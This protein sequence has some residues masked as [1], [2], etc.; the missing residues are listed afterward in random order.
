MWP[1]RRAGRVEVVAVPRRVQTLLFTDIVGSTDRLRELGDAPWAALLAR[2]HSVIRDVLATH[3]GREVNT[4]GDGF[5]ARFE[6]PASAVRAAVAAVAAVA[7]LGIEIRTGLHTGEVE[8]DRDEIAG[9]GVHL[10]ARVMAEAYPGQVL[11]TSTVRDLLAG[12][13]LGFVDQGVRELKGFAEIWR[14]FALDLSTVPGD[15]QAEA[16][17]WE[18]L[19]QGQGETGVPFP[20][21]L[22]VGRSTGY[23]GHEALLQRLEQARR[24]ATAGACRAVLLCGEPGIG[25]TRTAAEVAQ[26]AFAEGAIVLYGRCDE[27]VGAPYQPFAEALDWYTSH[28]D[29]TVLG[30]HPSELI[31]LQPL[32]EARLVGLPA[33][34]SSDPDRRST[35]CSRRPGPGWSS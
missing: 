21:L 31:R 26:A 8:L 28:V 15:G 25:K 3:G 4:A 7:A 13:G 23:V 22:S 1:L 34:V 35:C 24:Q 9:V 32:L 10:A 30:R 14:L 33:P 20:G 29:E 11:V 27:E 19:A 18:P 17:G 6:A 16:V 5:L 12:S 2:H